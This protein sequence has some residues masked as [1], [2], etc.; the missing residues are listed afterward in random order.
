[1]IATGATPE[2]VR[3]VLIQ[4]KATVILAERL[5]KELIYRRRNP[6]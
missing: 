1:M 3:Q 5:K 6:N 2:E 4:K